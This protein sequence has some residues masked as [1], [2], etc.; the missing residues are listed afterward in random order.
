MAVQHFPVQLTR[1]SAQL[2]G[3]LENDFRRCICK[4]HRA[5]IFAL[6]GRLKDSQPDLAAFAQD[7]LARRAGTEGQLVSF[8]KH[9]K[10]AKRPRAENLE[11]TDQTPE[12][13][14]GHRALD[15]RFESSE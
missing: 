5:E 1:N 7:L 15:R 8:V 4:R 14:L 3:D 13:E 12:Q 9:H 10:S 6:L 11:L 2:I